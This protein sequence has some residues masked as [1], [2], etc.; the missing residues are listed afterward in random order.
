MNFADETRGNHNFSDKYKLCIRF[1][2]FNHI[3]AYY[4]T[5]PGREEATNRSSLEMK[6]FLRKYAE[7][8]EISLELAYHDF[9]YSIWKGSTIRNGLIHELQRALENFKETLQVWPPSMH[10]K[11]GLKCLPFAS[12]DGLITWDEQDIKFLNMAAAVAAVV[13]G[14]PPPTRFHIHN[15]ILKASACT[16]TVT[17]SK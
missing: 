15:R 3:S 2:K 7:R 9:C 11:F 1:L 5:L 17:V 6:R 13:L 8:K 4:K 10:S 16:R 14:Q 12:K